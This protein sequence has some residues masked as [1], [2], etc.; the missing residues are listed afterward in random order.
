[1]ANALHIPKYDIKFVQGIKG[2]AKVLGIS[3]PAFKEKFE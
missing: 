2:K 3:N 1:M